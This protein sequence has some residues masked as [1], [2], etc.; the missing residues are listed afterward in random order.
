M[1][2]VISRPLGHKLTDA[3]LDATVTDSGAGALFNTMFA[4][5]LQDGDYVFIQSNIDSYN[6]FKYVDSFAYNSFRLRESE[7]GDFVP[8][9]QEA[10]ATYRISVLQH[11]WL[12]ITQPIVYELESD[13]WP[14]NQEDI[15]YNH[16][17]VDSQADAQGYTQLNLS[18]ALTDP[19]ELDFIELVGSG[20]LAGPYQIL[21]VLQPWSVIINL[22]YSASNDFSGYEVV[23][24]YNNYCINVEV[25]SGLG[26]EHPWYSEKPYELSA[27][28]RFTPGEDGRVKFS[29]SDILK[30]YIETRNRLTLD[31][32]PNNLDFMTAF[33]I[34]YYETYDESDGSEINTHEEGATNDIVNFEGHAVNSDMPFKSVYISHMSEYLSED[35]Y[36]AK[37]LLLQTRPVAVVGYFLDVS[38]INHLVGIDLK[39]SINK[40]LSGVVL[41]NEIQILSNIGVGV[42]RLPIVAES[43]FDE[44]CVKI[45]KD[46]I[47]GFTPAVLPDFLTWTGTGVADPVG[48]TWAVVGSEV[49]V[50]TNGL[51]LGNTSNNWYTPYAFE[52]GKSYSFG[53][54]IQGTVCGA[55]H[56]DIVDSI[57]AIIT[58]LSIVPLDANPVSGVYNLVAP[59]GAAGIIIW[60]F[61]NCSCGSPSGGCIKHII[62]FTN[63]TTGD[64]GTPQE[65]VTETL[66]ITVLKECDSTFIPDDDI[67]LTED[68]DFR[69]L[70]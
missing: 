40:S 55:W 66:C 60:M 23:K 20:D 61:D 67:R 10:D 25:W 4:H 68:G 3:E 57:G 22:A 7:N 6:G 26:V 41:E 42:I 9:K 16:R 47:P 19:Q 27:T 15:S 54:T 33:Y 64:A 70:E 59:A 44:Y 29:I 37:W 39:V 65:D 14:V 18:H 31:T 28:L 17:I 32:L 13:L 1:I 52:A 51:G 62:S 45:Y 53:Y 2:T 21:T 11:G 24:Y 63:L 46:A 49:Q 48:L 43:G 36:V 5:G 8:F 30:G 12:S 69:I 50:D 38:F 58:G 35:T 56:I 34:V